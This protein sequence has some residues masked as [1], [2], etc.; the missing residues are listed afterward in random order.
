MTPPT[1]PVTHRPPHRE[2]PPLEIL[3]TFFHPG[4]K[5]LIAFRSSDYLG[6]IRL[7]E[8][9]KCNMPVRRFRSVQLAGNICSP[10]VFAGVSGLEQRGVFIRRTGGRESAEAVDESLEAI[11]ERP[12]LQGLPQILATYGAG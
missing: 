4:A 1:E 11:F 9:R 10:V 5:S 8:R 6:S 7:H 2:P 3:D 12:D